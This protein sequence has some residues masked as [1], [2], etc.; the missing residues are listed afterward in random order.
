MGAKVVNGEGEGRSGE[1]EYA[2]TNGKV[3]ST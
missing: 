1:E 3:M 2:E